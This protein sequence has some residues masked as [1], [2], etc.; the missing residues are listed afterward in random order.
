VHALRLGEAQGT[1]DKPLDPGPRIYVFALDFL[2]VLLVHLMLLSI[3]MPLVGP[4]AVGVKLRDTKR[5]QQLVELQEDVVLPS[6]EHLCQHRARVVINGMPQPA[7]VRFPAYVTPHLVQLGRES[8]PLIEFFCTAYL[9]CDMLGMHNLQYRVVYLL[10]VRCLFF[11]SV[12]TVF[13]L[14]CKTRAVSR[15]PLACMAIS[16]IWCLTAGD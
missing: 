11:H 1:A 2:R 6:S 13:V 9:H 4:P 3:Q 14:M 10:E 12:M 5:C 15:I 16:T 7:G 8:T